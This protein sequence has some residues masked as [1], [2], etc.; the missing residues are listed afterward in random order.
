MR[1][2]TKILDIG[3]LPDSSGAGPHLGW[4]RSLLTGPL[5]VRYVPN[6]LAVGGKG[7]RSESSL[8]SVW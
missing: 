5:R 3:R 6:S 7:V 4:R 8:F 1:P 2:L